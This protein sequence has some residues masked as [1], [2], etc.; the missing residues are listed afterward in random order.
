[1]D[2]AEYKAKR[3]D[4]SPREIAR[5]KANGYTPPEQLDWRDGRGKDVHVAD[6]E[7]DGFDI[8]VRVVWDED[9][10]RGD[11][12]E[13]VNTRDDHDTYPTERYHD[14]LLRHGRPCEESRVYNYFRP[15][16]TARAN[17]KYYSKAGMSRGVAWEKAQEIMRSIVHYATSDDVY[18]YGV[19]VTA[20]KEGIELGENS[21]WGITFDMSARNV[22]TMREL[23]RC[24]DEC[25]D[26]AIH[27]AKEALNKLVASAS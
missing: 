3:T 11:D 22:E 1:M 19:I 5:G 16:E 2:Y 18:A 24:A 9:F 26:E 6:F 17:A 15:T 14:A 4:M 8:H 20:S 27:E 10:E 13:F 21:L 7:R 25:A 12:G 23:D